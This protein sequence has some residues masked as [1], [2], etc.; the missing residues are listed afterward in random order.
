MSVKR[1]IEKI[2]KK[3]TACGFL[4]CFLVGQTNAETLRT[5]ELI[6]V[7]K[8]KTGE[9]KVLGDIDGKIFLQ[10]QKDTWVVDAKTKL[11]FDGELLP[12]VI[13]PAPARPPRARMQEILSFDF[14]TGTNTP[15]LFYDKFDF[16]REQSRYR[17][18]LIDPENFKRTTIVKVF[19]PIEKNIKFAS[20]WQYDE[21]KKMWYNWGG[22]IED[23]NDNGNN[24]FSGQVLGTGKFTIWNEDPSPSFIPSFPIDEVQKVEQA[25]AEYQSVIQ[26]NEASSPSASDL[27]PGENTNTSQNTQND[28][29]NQDYTVPAVRPLNNTQ[30]IGVNN[31]V[32]NKIGTLTADTSM[33]PG[34]P[35]N[36]ST[37]QSS[38]VNI[39][40]RYIVCDQQQTNAGNLSPEKVSQNYPTPQ[41]ETLP[42]NTNWVKPIWL[43][44][45]NTEPLT[46]EQLKSLPANCK[47]VIPQDATKVQNSETINLNNLSA[48]TIPTNATL[49]K[50]GGDEETKSGFPIGVI[51]GVAI[52][53]I[54]G[55]FA[56]R[57]KEA[58]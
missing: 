54:S 56:L 14:V 30:G 7:T 41:R 58:Y 27:F 38:T 19:A 40:A 34:A 1:I 2:L 18:E 17:M 46:Q 20:L 13:I 43:D 26:Q 42:G 36:P 21:E 15:V 8:G 11:S 4:I 24:V 49:S 47:I 51:F 3:I 10:M 39:Y 37:G 29:F 44:A 48:S 35:A 52:L 31:P 45:S 57:K 16:L 28:Y 25:P 55:Y 50:T 23:S 6:T 12:P 9:T 22:R 53:I 5:S 33:N 32:A